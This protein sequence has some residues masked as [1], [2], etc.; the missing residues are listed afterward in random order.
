MWALAPHAVAEKRAHR[1]LS[2]LRRTLVES[3][4]YVAPS[5]CRR[6]PRWTCSRTTPS[7]SPNSA[8]GRWRLASPSVE[9]LTG[10]QPSSDSR[11]AWLS[12]S[13]TIARRPGAPDS[14][15]YSRAT[16]WL[17]LS[18]PRA[19]SSEPWALTSSSKRACGTCFKSWYSTVFWSGT[20]LL[21]SQ[22]RIVSNVRN[23]RRVNAV[24]QTSKQRTGQSWLQTCVGRAG[25]SGC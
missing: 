14:C 21:L 22:V 25:G 12:S 15:P 13:A 18:S 17:L 1:S 4:R 23:V 6:R 19:A 9:R 16:S 3:I 7:R 8:A 24:R 10:S 20:A 5:M 2:A 11:A